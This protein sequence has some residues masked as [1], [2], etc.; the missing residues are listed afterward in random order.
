M[1]F[2]L[3]VS[4]LQEIQAMMEDITKARQVMKQEQENFSQQAAE[5][6]NALKEAE[7]LLL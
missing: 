6:E 4:N 5:M 2:C 1:F 3:F 7:T